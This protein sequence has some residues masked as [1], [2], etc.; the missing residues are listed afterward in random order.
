MRIEV[1]DDIVEIQ[2]IFASE[3]SCVCRFE[4]VKMRTA[5]EV[6]IARAIFIAAGI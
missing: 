6:A 1:D 2:T 4:E 5:Y 3:N